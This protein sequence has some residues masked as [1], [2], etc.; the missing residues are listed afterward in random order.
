MSN[1]KPV[2]VLIHTIK[3][4]NLNMDIITIIKNRRS[5]RLFKNDKVEKETLIK[6]VECGLFAPN[7]QN[8]Q[9]WHFLLISNEEKKKALANLKE[10]NNREH[11]LSAPVS[12][13]VCIDKNKSPN[14]IIEDGA[15]ASQ[16]ILLAV[17]SF[18]LNS[19]YL[20]AYKQGDNYLENGIRKI[21][22]I[23]ENIFPVSILPIGY[24]D[25]K[26]EILPKE[27]PKLENILH[28]DIW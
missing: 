16:N 28:T 12:I 1:Y 14:R 24:G 11:I 20:T 23:P 15:L 4:Y 13:L 7:A 25:S 18:G 10:E 9:P 3:C 26:E 8:K 27:L 19:T 22:S 21:F 2:S 5:H 17:E 6:I